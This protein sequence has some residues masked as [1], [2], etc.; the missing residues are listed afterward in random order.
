M[1]HICPKTN[2]PIRLLRT[3][4]KIMEKIM[5]KR[6]ILLLNKHNILYKYQCGF[7]HNYLTFMALI[8]IVDNIL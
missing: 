6:I 1:K 2:R 5:Y 4:N 7:R 3:L 8:E